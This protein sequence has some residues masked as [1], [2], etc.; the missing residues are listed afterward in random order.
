MIEPLAQQ[1][2]AKLLTPQFGEWINVKPLVVRLNQVLKKRSLRKVSIAL[3]NSLKSFFRQC[4]MC[5]LMP[6]KQNISIRLYC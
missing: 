6:I 1:Q 2:Q 5:I 4:L 3:S